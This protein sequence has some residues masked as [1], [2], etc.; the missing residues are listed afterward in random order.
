[1]QWV[2]RRNR[3][4]PWMFTPETRTPTFPLYCLR[5]LLR[6]CSHQ[7]VCLRKGH[8]FLAPGG[9]VSVTVVTEITA[10]RSRK[11]NKKTCLH[12]H[13]G[14]NQ[15]A[16]H[17]LMRWIFCCIMRCVSVKWKRNFGQVEKRHCQLDVFPST[18]LEQVN[19]VITSEGRAVA[20]RCSHA[21]S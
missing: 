21:S 13:E 5:L 4:M 20:G 17:L 2:R 12:V 1:M 11:K 3:E 19:E 18:G 9:S 8:C 7:F 6:R 14:H 10:S 15:I 16:H